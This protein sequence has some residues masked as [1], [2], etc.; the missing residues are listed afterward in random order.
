[1]ASSVDLPMPEPAK[2]PMRW[3]AQSGVKK[4][5][6]LTPVFSGV[7]ARCRR[8][9]GG[10][11][12]SLRTGR[13]PWNSGA[14]SSMGAPSALTMRPFQEGCGLMVTKPRR[15]AA[16]PS[17]A[18]MAVSNGLT[19]TPLSSMRTTSPSWGFA[20]VS[21]SMHSPSLTNGDRPETRQKA[22]ATSVTTPL[23][24][25]FGQIRR[26]SDQPIQRVESVQGGRRR[27]SAAHP[28]AP[29]VLMASCSEVSDAASE[30]ETIS[31]ARVMLI[32]RVIS[33]TALT[34]A[35]SM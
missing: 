32:S 5:M 12:R 27:R 15:R 19:V 23:T 34:L 3:P 31:K 4:S 35:F 10:G 8:M 26:R 28:D 6:T 21:S 20:P 33:I 30:A 22:G 25:I 1:M 7:R 2:M 16:V 13:S 18:F 17:P 9:A 24:R 11:S 29:S 14:P